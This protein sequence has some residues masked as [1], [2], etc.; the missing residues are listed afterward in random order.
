MKTTLDEHGHF[1][2]FGGQYV[3][4]TLMPAI[5]ELTVAYNEVQNDASF[6]EEFA[7]LLHQYVGRPSPLYSAQRLTE[8]WGGAK[9]YLK[10]ED[11]NHTGAHKLNNTIGQVLV[12]E[13]LGKKRIIAETASISRSR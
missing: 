9:V 11:L 8:A 5:H 13:R 2:D 10:R 7:T 3:A 6:M 4:E 12:A 1:G